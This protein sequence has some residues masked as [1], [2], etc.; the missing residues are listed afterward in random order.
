MVIW[1]ISL[2]VGGGQG[3]D[4]DEFFLHP[5]PLASFWVETD[6]QLPTFTIKYSK[7]VITG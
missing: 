6:C 4:W 7:V 1:I 2:L 3:K 5:N